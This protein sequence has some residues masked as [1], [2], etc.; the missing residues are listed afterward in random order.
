DEVG[1]LVAS[2]NGMLAEIEQRDGELAAHRDHLEEQVAQRTADLV[3]ANEQ[4]VAAKEVAEA[5]SITKSEFVANMSHEIRTPLNGVIGMTGLLL[6]TRLDAEQQEYAETTRTSAESLLAIV[7]DVLDFSKIEAGKLDV[8]SI[9]FDLRTVVEK[10][11]DIVS[12][13]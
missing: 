2:F 5:A 9:D 3:R 8:E 1:A 13:K 12:P 4:L 7:N 11:C 6:R 10:A